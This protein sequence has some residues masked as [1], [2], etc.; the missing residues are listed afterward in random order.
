MKMVQLQGL[1]GLIQF[2][3][4]GYR[5]EVQMDVVQLHGHVSIL[6]PDIKGDLSCFP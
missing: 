3:T 2:N 4:S 6:K 1:T 5:T